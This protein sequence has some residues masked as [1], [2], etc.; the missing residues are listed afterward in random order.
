VTKS[1]VNVDKDVTKTVAGYVVVGGKTLENGA[2]GVTQETVNFCA[3]TVNA[4][5]GA[6]PLLRDDKLWDKLTSNPGETAWTALVYGTHTVDDYVQNHLVSDLEW[7]GDQ[8]GKFL[9][10]TPG[11]QSL[12]VL[13]CSTALNAAA[14]AAT[15][16]MA[17]HCANTVD[18]ALVTT[19]LSTIKEASFDLVVSCAVYHVLKRTGMCGGIAYSL[20]YQLA[21]NLMDDP[22]S[23][24]C[25]AAVSC[26]CDT[27]KC[28]FTCGYPVPAYCDA[29]GFKDD[30]KA[31]G[32][33]ITSVAKAT[34][35]PNT[36]TP[37]IPP[38]AAYNV[39]TSKTG[40]H[41]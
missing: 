18:Q 13:A 6:N 9:C 32:D 27:D 39:P 19:L 22:Y 28:L 21:T 2:I 4:F 8:I 3:R 17:P 7:L 11:L 33:A 1:V 16:G 14:C 40:A 35:P 15:D 23:S 5:A 37:T 30:A 38:S 25:S 12:E 34:L 29:Q 20:G 41:F 31:I 24:I 36:R 10:D 26:S